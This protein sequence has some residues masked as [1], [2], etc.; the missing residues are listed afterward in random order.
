MAVI[1]VLV[2]LIV[3]MLVLL[4]LRTFFWLLSSGRTFSFNLFLLF[5][6]L[7]YLGD[8]LSFF[9]AFLF[10]GFFLDWFLLCLWVGRNVVND[11]VDEVLFF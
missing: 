7:F 10:G 1:F 8:P 6:F 9:W 3:L 2:L 11:L 4:V 5:L